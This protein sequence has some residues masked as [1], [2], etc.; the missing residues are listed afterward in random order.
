MKIYTFDFNSK[1]NNYSFRNKSNASKILDDFILSGISKT[2][3]SGIIDPDYDETIIIP[4]KK[5]INI[6][7]NI[8]KKKPTL[9]YTRYSDFLKAMNFF[10]NYNNED[11]Y[12]F[13]LDDGTP[14]KF[15]DDEIQI[16][17]DLIPRTRMTESFF[18]TL[19]S[20]TKK[21]IINIYLKISK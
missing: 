14:V 9:D 18:K 5:N 15:F 8:N 6:N 11:T 3:T 1:K 17:Y 2:R 13:L 20:K 7:I 4:R 16:G 10:S 12:D 21:D 19:P